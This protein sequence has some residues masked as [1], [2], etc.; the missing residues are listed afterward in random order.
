MKSTKMLAA[1][2]GALLLVVLAAVGAALHQ[3]WLTAGA[4]GLI[5]T[6]QLV[7]SLDTNRRTRYL[8][9]R[10]K[11]LLQTVA[12]GTKP[13]TAPAARPAPGTPA[14]SARPAAAPQ[15]DVTGAVRLIQAQYVGRLDR[16]QSALE[17]AAEDLR[18]A[19][20]DR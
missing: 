11:T 2:G 10:V 5:M 9:R 20:D 8:P 4:L 19:R 15:Q 13:G 3:Y 14:P 1:V 7:V 12:V 17:S 18:S 6:A 16:A